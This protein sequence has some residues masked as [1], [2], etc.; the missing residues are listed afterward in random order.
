MLTARVRPSLYLCGLAVAWGIVA[1]IMALTN[2][3]KQLAGV[4]FV[5]GFVESVFIAFYLSS[6]YRRYELASRFAVYYTAVAVAGGLS[7]L[8]AGIIEGLR[9]ILSRLH[10]LVLHGRLSSNT[11]WLT[12]EEYLVAAQSFAYDGL[13]NAQCAS[14]HITE[15]E[16]F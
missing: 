10:P 8:L 11:R 13:G 6:W 3:W 2:N 14:G 15:K 16:E 1:A 12:P 7:G 5:L 9:L 4:I